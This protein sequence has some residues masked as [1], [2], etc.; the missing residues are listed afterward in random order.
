MTARSSNKRLL[1][2]NLLIPLTFLAVTVAFFIETLDYPAFEDVGPAAA[3]HLWMVFI[4]AFCLFLVGQAILG[5]GDDDPVSGRIGAVY[6]ALAWMAAYLVAIQMVGY[7][8]ST[9]VFMV[10]AML[11]LGYR[12]VPVIAAVTGGWLV[13]CYV[14][15]YKLLYIPLPVGPL[16]EPF[17]G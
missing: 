10:G 6:V 5:K 7:F 17:I 4:A 11:G 14:V 15:F 3:P 2:G 16:L 8:I 12:N 9:M 13:F 1:S